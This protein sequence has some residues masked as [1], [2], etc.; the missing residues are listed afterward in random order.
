M[1]NEITGRAAGR[2]KVL[3]RLLMLLLF[4]GTAAVV[5]WQNSRLTV[6]WDLSYILENA[7]RIAAGDVPYRDF[8]F[9]YA[10]LTFAMQAAIIR[11]FGRAVVHHMA[12]AAICGGTASA[13]TYAIVR[14]IANDARVAI[15]LTL[16]LILLGIY[17]I[18][19]HPFYDPDACLV[20]LLLLAGLLRAETP[21]ALFLLGG[22]CVVP[23]FVKQNIGLAFLAALIA[24]AVLSRERRR[25]VPLFAG[26][27]ASGAIAAALV[28]LVFGASNYIRWTIRFAAE[29]RL[30]PL[31]QQLAIFNDPVLWCWLAFAIAGAFAM[32][33]RPRVGAL[34]V[35]LPLASLLFGDGELQLLRL[36]PF[37]LALIA[38]DSVARWRD[39]NSV[40]QFL[41]LVIAATIGGTFLSQSTWGSTYGIW[42][43]LAILFAFLLR[44]RAYAPALATLLGASMLLL[45]WPYV[46][47]NHRL[48][49]V[50]WD[51]DEGEL[52]HATLAPLRG[53][54]MRGNWLSDFEELVDWTESN[55]PRGDA[56]LSLPGEDL[57]YF[58]TGRR[59]RVPVLMFDR[60][61]NPYDARQLARIA[62]ERDVRW[63]IVKRE[64]QINGTP[65]GNLDAT[66]ALL[67][68]RFAIAV[69]LSNYDVYRRIPSR[70]GSMTVK[71]VTPR[72]ASSSSLQPSTRISPS[73]SKSPS[74]PSSS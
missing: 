29:R 55:I 31:A 32:R 2:G 6:L 23:L 69:R 57:F 41:P 66:L 53:L 51:A 52:E 21:R 48:T 43:L 56:I 9:P 49:Y 5:V 28:A 14:R 67:R 71:P 13:L 34:V 50:K 72:A 15:A 4:A 17:C 45:A 24:L 27:G 26:I 47:D 19:P 40:A 38:I 37:A 11:L 39:E 58:T 30:P 68:P 42:P 54:S 59:P 74:I 8:P 22:P 73:S 61:I 25:L 10:P 1:P 63:L 16:P 3:D 60:T 7:T 12:W 36:W 35:A 62:E 70:S 33:K 64:L 18:F 46:R 44:G 65:M 20:L